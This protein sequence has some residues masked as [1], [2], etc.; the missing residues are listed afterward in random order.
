MAR[1][2]PGY[3]RHGIL[4]MTEPD[5]VQ[6]WRNTLRKNMRIYAD[7][8]APLGI[9]EVRNDEK[10]SSVSTESALDDEDREPI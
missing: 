10:A 9:S 6:V 4:T 2:T 5:H 3:Q 1:A 7:M 8:R